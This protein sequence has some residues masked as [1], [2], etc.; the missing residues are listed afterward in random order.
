MK[1]FSRKQLRMSA[2]HY[3]SGGYY[4]ITISAY[5]NQRIFG[6]IRDGEMQLSAI[7]EIAR[8]HISMIA[9][10]YPDTDVLCSVVMPNHIHIVLRV[11]HID[12]A[13]L[14]ERSRPKMKVPKIVQSYKASVSREVRRCG[15]CC[16]MPIWH[17]SYYDVIIR[18]E[19]QLTLV[20]AYIKCNP[21][22][23]WLDHGIDL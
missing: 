10:A 2:Y 3:S 22:R 4:F 13:E 20:Y 18:S 21:I 11:S 15:Y 7:G 23:W 9:A 16:G 6:K 19:K 12:V 17:K 1:Y 5:Q 8:Q 14:K